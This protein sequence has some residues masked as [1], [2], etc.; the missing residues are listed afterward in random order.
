MSGRAQGCAGAARAAGWRGSNGWWPLVRS[1]RAL[2]S[3][4]TTIRK[5]INDYL[6]KN[7]EHPIENILEHVTGN[8][9]FVFTSGDLSKVRDQIQANK[10]PAP[11]RV[12][13]IAPSDVFVEPGPTGCDPGQTQWFQALNIQTKIN[14][15]QIEIVSRVHICKVGEKVTESQAALLQKLNIR[16]FSYGLKVTKV[17]DA[18]NVFEAA[19]LDVSAADL[20]AKMAFGIATVA[21]VSLEIGYPTKASVVH[22]INNAYKTLISFHLGTDYKFA[23]AQKFEDFLANP[24][25]FAVAAPSGGAVAA[26]PAAAEE[27]S[28]E[29]VQGGAGGLFGGD[30]DDF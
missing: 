6:K 7:P 19:I 23:K 11:A 26:A 13:G 1:R 30:D 5:V 3:P 8:I 25:A 24:G 2:N 27:S 14:K 12:G 18:G 16:P 29:S 21:S 10:V 20:Y 4:Q 17:Y 28:S 15:G 22:S 9:G